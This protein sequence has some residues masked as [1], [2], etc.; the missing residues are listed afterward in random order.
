MPLPFDY[1]R[2]HK[3][4]LV[5]FFIWFDFFPKVIIECFEVVQCGYLHYNN[6]FRVFSS[7]KK[8]EKSN[9]KSKI[10]DM[11]FNLLKMRALHVV[12][13][14]YFILFLPK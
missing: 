13:S 1:A 4:G 10:D 12:L 5:K 14:F 7:E 2:K 6:V 11:S 8:V 3:L 9:F